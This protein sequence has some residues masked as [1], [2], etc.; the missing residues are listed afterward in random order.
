M[1]WVA[2]G[3][4][5][6]FFASGLDLSRA[7]GPDVLDVRHGLSLEGAKLPTLHQVTGLNVPSQSFDNRQR[8]LYGL[9]LAGSKSGRGFEAFIPHAPALS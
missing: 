8:E 7:I 5:T 9:L 1:S 2:T 3:I 6:S 4:P